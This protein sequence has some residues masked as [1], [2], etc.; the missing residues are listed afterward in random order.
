VIVSPVAPSD[1]CMCGSATLAMVV[2]RI[3]MIVASITPNVSSPLLRTGS[4]A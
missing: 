3:C 1:V 4:A 2:S